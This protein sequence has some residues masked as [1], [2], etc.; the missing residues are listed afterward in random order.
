MRIFKSPHC[1]PSVF[2]PPVPRVFSRPKPH[3]IDLPRQTA[4]ACARLLQEQGH[5]IENL[6]DPTL[7]PFRLVTTSFGQVLT[8]HFKLESL[9]GPGE[10]S[11]AGQKISRS[12]Q[13]HLRKVQIPDF[14]KRISK[15]ALARV[16]RQFPDQVGKTKLFFFYNE[17]VILK[18]RAD[19]QTVFNSIYLALGFSGH[20]VPEAEL[21]KQQT[22]L[23][24]VREQDVPLDLFLQ[25]D[26]ALESAFSALTGNAS[27]NTLALRSPT[28]SDTQMHTVFIPFRN[29][30]NELLSQW[31]EVTE[32]HHK[33]GT[34]EISDILTYSN[35]PKDVAAA[36][37][38]K[39]NDVF[40]AVSENLSKN[41]IAPYYPRFSLTL[42][43]VVVDKDI[44]GFVVGIAYARDEVHRDQKKIL[45]E[46]VSDEVKVR[47]TSFHWD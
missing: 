10:K 24:Y 13:G 28:V 43:P 4:E 40:I 26:F 1:P 14:T 36:M 8:G 46:K 32:R 12:L 16:K 18:R 21:E 3:P 27:G 23:Q 6:R 2:A 38:R 34:R 5:L 33:L 29:L 20:L 47:E 19:H 42:S 39:V 15:E 41:G 22:A 9:A 31:D 25:I 45:F 17:L 35:F 7:I 30:P 37:R 44:L 11:C